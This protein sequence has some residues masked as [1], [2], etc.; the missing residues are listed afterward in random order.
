MKVSTVA[1]VRVQTMMMMPRIVTSVEEEEAASCLD[2]DD[3]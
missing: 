3:Q 1:A 2:L